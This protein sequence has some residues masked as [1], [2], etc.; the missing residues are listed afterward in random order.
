MPISEGKMLK[1]MVAW[2]AL[3]DAM[4]EAVDFQ[5]M[6]P[7]LPPKCQALGHTRGC[8]NFKMVNNKCCQS[9][10]IAA[11]RGE[12]SVSE[13]RTFCH[14]LSMSGKVLFSEHPAL[15][16]NIVHPK[17]IRSTWIDPTAGQLWV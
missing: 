5:H 17:A 11:L 6:G 12:H 10:S 13:R 16:C 9:R 15:L 1:P 3:A 4:R 7:P 2:S 8:D 14:V